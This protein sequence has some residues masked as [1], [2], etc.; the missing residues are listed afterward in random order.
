MIE[1]EGGPA[2]EIGCTRCLAIIEPAGDKRPYHENFEF[3]RHRLTDVCKAL[4]PFGLRLGVGY[5]AAD[6]LRKGQA[7]QFIHEMDA[8]TLLIKM[9][10]APNLGVLLDLWDLHVSGGNVETVR[11][12]S[13]EQIVAVRVA[14]LPEDAPAAPAYAA[15]LA[16]LLDAIGVEQAH[17]VGHSLGAI[18]AA[19]FCRLFPDRV[20][21]LVLA[22]PAAGYGA[23]NDARQG[24]HRHDVRRHKQKLG[25]NGDA[26]DLQFDLQGV[27]EAEDKGGREGPEGI[28]F[29]KDHGCQSN[30]TFASGHYF[31]TN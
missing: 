2:A 4:E 8:L 13:A 29:A 23:A 5:R 28:P 18:V 16:G 27:G 19:S 11:G 24:N 10:D 21:N 25:R 3:H 15:A 14:D 7:F 9:I 20:V 17:I 30:E 26:Q 12:L 6:D 1:Q 31:V 22:D